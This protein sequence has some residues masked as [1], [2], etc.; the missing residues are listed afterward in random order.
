MRVLSP[1]QTPAAV[2]A[3]AGVRWI[4]VFVNDG[5]VDRAMRLLQ[6]KMRN[7]GKF[8]KVKHAHYYEKPAARRVRIKE[9]R[10]THFRMKEIQ[11]RLKYIEELRKAGH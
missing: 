2:A 1:S 7:E 8:F 9:Q 10:D 4:E 6:N 3:P 5:D 11:D